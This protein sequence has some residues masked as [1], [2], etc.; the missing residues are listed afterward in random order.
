MFQL[1]VFF[2]NNILIYGCYV[3]VGNCGR[4]F[5]EKLYQLIGVNIAVLVKL[6]GSIVFGVIW[7]LG[8]VRGEL[9]VVVFFI[10]QI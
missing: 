5:I 2:V 10:K 9:Q 3:V 6:I 8:F 1:E 7:E 4:E